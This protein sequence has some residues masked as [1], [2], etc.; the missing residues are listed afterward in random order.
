[1]PG[2]LLLQGYAQRILVVD[3][4]PM[5]LRLVRDNLQH[6]GFEVVTAASGEE[7]LAVINRAGLPHLAIVDIT[8]P[9]MDGFQFCQ[10]VQSFSDLPII[11]LTAVDEEE[12]IIRGLKFYAE[13]YVTKPFRPRELT[14][15]VQR[16]L[17]RIKSF[18]YTLTPK[19]A[20][21]DR[22][23]VDFVHQQVKI[24]GEPV[25]LTP[26]ETKILY[27][28]LQNA[29]QIVTTD[30]LLRRIWPNEEIFE[31]A[32]RVHIARLRKKIEETPASPRYIV[33]KRGIGYLFPLNQ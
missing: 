16:V 19:T 33:T 13:D 12:A 26:L 27:I 9:G 28:L 10:T 4:D 31:E 8:M 1:M 30:F 29:G 18:S 5:I 20:V 24:A 7:A 25:S 23:V 6:E 22:F 15:R 17:R 21:N 32:L 11:L 14:L 2:P 3:D